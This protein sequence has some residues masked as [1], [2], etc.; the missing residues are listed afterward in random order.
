MAKNELDK[1]NMEITTTSWCPTTWSVM[2][3]IHLCFV[4][5]IGSCRYRK[6]VLRDQQIPSIVLQ[7]PAYRQIA[8]L[9]L[10]KELSRK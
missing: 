5:I 9:T 10:G 2:Q 7:L 8:H 6:D 1:E 4:A 3:L